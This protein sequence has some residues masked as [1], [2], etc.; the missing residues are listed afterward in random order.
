M[1]NDCMNVAHNVARC[2]LSVSFF[3][4]EDSSDFK[5]C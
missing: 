2:A 4:C 3:C 1:V 5:S